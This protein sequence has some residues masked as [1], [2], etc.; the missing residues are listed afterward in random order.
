[1]KAE[2][3]SEYR[4]RSGVIRCRFESTVSGSPKSSSISFGRVGLDGD[5][6][7]FAFSA[8][9]FLSYY[10]RRHGLKAGKS[11]KNWYAQEILNVLDRIT[12]KFVI[13]NKKTEED[14]NNKQD[15]A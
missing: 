2:S 9:K 3:S 1:M 10:L 7:L 14:A 4:V 11:M 8:L 6:D 12:D 13:T 5:E 15:E